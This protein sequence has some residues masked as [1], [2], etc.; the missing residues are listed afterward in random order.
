MKFI[1][2]LILVMFAAI[3]ITPL[4][5]CWNR[6]EIDTLGITICLGVDKTENGFLVTEQVLNPTAIASKRPIN[7]SPIILY[8]MED[9]D[10]FSALR[11]MTTESPRKIYNSHMRVIVIGEAAAKA[12]ILN[13]IDFLT[14]DHEFRTDFYFAIAKGTT[15]NKILS[16][17]TPLDSIP[18]ISIYERIQLSEK[19]WAPTKAVRIIELCNA[20]ISEGNNP[21]LTGIE[22]IG[23]DTSSSVE[24]LKN[25]DLSQAI[26]ITPIAAFK[27][28]KL[29]GWLTENESKGY[30]YILGNVNSTVGYVEFESGERITLEAI[31]EKSEIT[32]YLIDEKPAIDVSIKIETQIGTVIGDVDVTKEE[33]LTK[34]KELSEQRIKSMCEA[35]LK[36]TQEELGTDIFG[37]GEVIHRAY[38]KLWKDLKADWNHE[39]KSLPVNIRAEC[40]ITRLGEIGKSFFA[41]EE[42]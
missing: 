36:K 34:I 5:G 22:V 35:V 42:E 16:I 6:R 4:S 41:K 30:N 40:E 9:K 23:T 27:N 20:L 8:S 3:L 29:A 10:I 12:G 31:R 18:G 19:V 26:R 37:F 28:D 38:P 21:V 24:D 32:A 1:K 2:K 25:S 14:R 7:Q 33:V 17:L 11:K 15:A 13:F 39:F